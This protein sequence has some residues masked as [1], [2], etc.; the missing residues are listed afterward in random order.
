[1]KIPELKQWSDYLYQMLKIRRFE[2]RL[3]QL[4]SLGYIHGT[5]HLYVGQE[6]VAVG[7]CSALGK[8]DYITS[9]HRGH[10]HFIAKGGDVRRILAEIWGLEEGYCMGRGGTQHMADF[11]IGNLGSNG[12]TGGQI[13]IATGAALAL[14]MQGQR[15]VVACFFGDGAANEGVFHESLN[16]ASVWGLPVIY[17]CENNLYAMSTPVRTAFKIPDIAA[18]ATAYGIPGYIVDGMDVTEVRR[19]TAEAVEVARQGRGPSLIECKTYRFLGHSKSDNRNYR[20]R[21][22]EAEWE[23]RD[24]IKL[25]SEKL[26]ARGMTADEL[27]QIENRVTKEIDGA[28]EFSKNL[29]ETR[30]HS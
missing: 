22:E 5:I 7:V 15:Q 9:T 13:P 12:I 26:L 29:A 24:P 2:E 25:L 16:I 14:K 6:A 1:M 20:T 10:G 27:A 8:R 21:E 4:F 23:A 19:V 11:N 17:V 18:R 30:L 28:V 3:N